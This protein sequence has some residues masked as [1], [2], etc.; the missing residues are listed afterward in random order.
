MSKPIN[1]RLLPTEMQQV[2]NIKKLCNRFQQDLIT[3]AKENV[4]KM[5][6]NIGTDNKDEYS[7]DDKVLEVGHKTK[8]TIDPFAKQINGKSNPALDKVLQ[9][10]LIQSIFNVIEKESQT[11]ERNFKKLLEETIP[12]IT[13]DLKT[14]IGK[15]TLKLDKQ[16]EIDEIVISCEI[17][18]NNIPPPPPG[19][20]PSAS[21]GFTEKKKKK[22]SRRGR[23]N[24]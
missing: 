21:D 4:K 23:L 13:I 7:F 12:A 3:N 8:I 11:K 1:V 18:T 16:I 2:N 10:C 24:H 9:I 14:E 5:T 17:K 20:P 15:V 19:K 6:V 22:N